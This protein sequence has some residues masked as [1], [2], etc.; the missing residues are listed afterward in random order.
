MNRFRPVTGSYARS[1]VPSRTSTTISQVALTTQNGLNV[2][3]P[4]GAESGVTAEAVFTGPIQAPVTKG[5]R[6]G[7]LQIQIPGVG[8]ANVPLVAAEDV[9][10][11]GFV[12]RLKGAAMRLGGEAWTAARN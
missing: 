3:M 5:D 9:A 12:G 10:S 8:P 1:T 6:V 7:T 2:L 11:A 4:I